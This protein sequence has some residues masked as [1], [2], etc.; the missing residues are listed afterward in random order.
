MPLSNHITPGYVI[1]WFH[2]DWEFF[3]PGFSIDN[4]HD[5]VMDVLGE[6]PNVKEVNTGHTGVNVAFEDVAIT[7]DQLIAAIGKRIKKFVVK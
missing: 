5:A 2:V 6:M 3:G 1:R 4:Q 7:N